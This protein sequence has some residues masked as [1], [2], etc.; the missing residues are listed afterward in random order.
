VHLGCALR[1][2][3]EIRPRTAVTVDNPFGQQIVNRGT[4][5]RLVDAEQIVETEVFSDDDDQ[6]LDRDRCARG[7]CVRGRTE[8]DKRRC[9]KQGGPR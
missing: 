1:C 7:L 4:R 6:M 2:V 8:Y 3:G 5:P 9:R